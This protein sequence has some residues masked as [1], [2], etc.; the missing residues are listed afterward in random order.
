[1]VWDEDYDTRIIT[2]INERFKAPHES[3][4]AV[5]EHEGSLS[6]LWD[7]EFTDPSLLR[8]DYVGDGDQW[9]TSHY[10]VKDGVVVEFTELQRQ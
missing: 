3:P 9:S 4:L 5:C 1:M 6:I 8:D 2:V 7:S 10:Y